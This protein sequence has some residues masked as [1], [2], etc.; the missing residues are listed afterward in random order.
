MV[1]AGANSFCGVV[2]GAD[3]R[4]I[5]TGGRQWWDFD[6]DMVCRCDQGCAVELCGAGCHGCASGVG[7]Y[8]VIG[9]VRIY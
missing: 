7:E 5:V 3:V 1:F 8:A 4:V 9:D 2:D 6:G